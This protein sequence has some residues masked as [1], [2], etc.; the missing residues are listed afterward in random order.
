MKRCRPASSSGRHTSLRNV[1]PSH[2]RTHESTRLDPIRARGYR[3]APHRA[4]CRSASRRPGLDAGAGRR[5]CGHRLSEH[6]REI[7]PL[8]DD[9]AR[10]WPRAERS[11]PRGFLYGI[12]DKLAV[13]I[14]FPDIGAQRYTGD[15]PHPTGIDA[16][17][18][19]NSALQDLRFDVR[20]NLSRKGFVVTPFV[21][22][23]VPS[24]DYIYWAHSAVGRDLNE[25]QVGAFWAKLLDPVLPGLFVTGR[26]SYAF[27]ERAVDISHNRSNLDLELGYFVKPEFRVFGVAAG[28]LTHGGI[29]F[30]PAPA[31][32]AALPLALRQH[33]DQIGRDNF[34]NVGGGAAFNVTPTFDVFG[35]VIHTV[36][37]RNIH[38]MQYGATIG[39]SWSFM[40]RHARSTQAVQP[41]QSEP[42]GRRESW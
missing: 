36:T 26:Y 24:H 28:Q 14:G 30:P 31:V 2:E 11:A 22:S 5:H 32:F 9:P 20:D 35:S 3:L 12:T 25:L 13:S 16:T 38:E 33:H 29:D 42:L 19:Y 1:P 18:R 6:V 37:G 23:V 21:G 39:V 27:V 40:T 4:R 8:H 17:H 10:S 41:P 7:P 15:Y 34:L